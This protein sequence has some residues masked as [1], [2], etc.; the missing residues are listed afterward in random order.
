MNSFRWTSFKHAF[1]GFGVLWE[2]SNTKIHITLASL[3]FFLGFYLHITSIEWIIILI[4]ITLVLATESINTAVELMCDHVS[5][6][7][8]KRIKCIKDVSA[9]AVLVSA[10]ASLTIGILIFWPYL[11]LM[12]R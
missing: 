11:S 9:F 5:P 6:E 3:T 4:C 12:L 8:H 10:I 7:Y 2:Q 1:R